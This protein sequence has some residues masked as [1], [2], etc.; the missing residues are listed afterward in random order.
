MKEDIIK[1]DVTSIGRRCRL[2]SSDSEQN[3]EVGFCEHESYKA[4]AFLNSQGTLFHEP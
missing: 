1:G 2:H 4:G 3:R